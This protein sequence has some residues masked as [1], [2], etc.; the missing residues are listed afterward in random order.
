MSVKDLGNGWK[1]YW[2][3]YGNANWPSDETYR[4][5]EM[6]NELQ[7]RLER[8]LDPEGDSATEII[9]SLESNHNLLQ[10]PDLIQPS[11]LYR[12]GSAW[13]FVWVPLTREKDLDM[14]EFFLREKAKEEK[15]T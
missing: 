10:E 9:I 8:P 2:F 11:I 4:Y 5:N 3:Y 6:R 15:T 7:V 1:E 13:L 12:N 14:W